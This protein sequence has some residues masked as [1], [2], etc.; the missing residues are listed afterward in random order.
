M[1]QKRYFHNHLKDLEL[2]HISFTDIT[3]IWPLLPVETTSL[4]EKIFWCTILCAHVQLHAT[5]VGHTLLPYITRFHMTLTYKSEKWI[6]PS[7]V[8]TGYVDRAFTFCCVWQWP[9]VPLIYIVNSQ[10]CTSIAKHSVLIILLYMYVV[11]SLCCLLWLNW[12]NIHC[13]GSTVKKQNK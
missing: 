1:N 11:N 4:S 10:W 8:L 3:P 6:P 12:K 5:V 7:R 9:C 13:Y 2:C